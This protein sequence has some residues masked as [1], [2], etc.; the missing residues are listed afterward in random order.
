VQYN[1]ESA[2]VVPRVADDASSGIHN[3]LK[4][5]CGRLGCPSENGVTVVHACDVTKA[6][7]NAA[8]DSAS[9]ERQTGLR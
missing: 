8:A 5:V 6:W 1:G 9:S 4:L 3:W 7:T 2:I